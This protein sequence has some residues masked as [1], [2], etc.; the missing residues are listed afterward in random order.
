MTDFSLTSLKKASVLLDVNV[1]TGAMN[2]VIPESFYRLT[3]SHANDDSSD[4]DHELYSDDHP[5]K[6]PTRFR[7][8]D[9]VEKQ[10]GVRY[11]TKARAHDRKYFT[12]EYPFD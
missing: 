4:V 2:I 11:P 7:R 9:N 3:L 1:P 6:Y 8:S 12:K 5:Q 10:N